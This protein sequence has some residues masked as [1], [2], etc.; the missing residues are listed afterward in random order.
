M[1]GSDRDAAFEK[2]IAQVNTVAKEYEGLNRG[3]F[4]NVDAKLAE[5]KTKLKEAG[6]DKIIAEMQTQIDAWAAT[7]PK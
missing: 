6:I 4:E 1:R 2:E 7:L 5:Y 3:R